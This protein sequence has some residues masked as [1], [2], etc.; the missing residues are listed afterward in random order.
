[1]LRKLRHQIRS[2]LTDRRTRTDRDYRAQLNRQMHKDN[3]FKGGAWEATIENLESV[4]PDLRQLVT[5]DYG[6]GPLG[7]VSAELGEG[8]ICF[9][10]YVE[11][12]NQSPWNRQFDVLF[13]SDVMEHM[14]EGEVVEFCQNIAQS[15]AD[16]VY[17]HI[18]TRTAVKQLPNGV[19]AHL[20]VK[21][22]EWWVENLARHLGQGFEL[23][24]GQA[25]LV[26]D[27]VTV[28]F[29]RAARTAAAA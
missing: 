8:T 3:L 20:T 25:D 2:W 11:K 5:L 14:T 15:S 28:C 26:A 13:S 4:V 6:C 1:M 27:S 12:L 9:D 24:Y 21:P 7:G 17:L 29:H 10:P 16:W 18:S 19:N 22:G 23:V